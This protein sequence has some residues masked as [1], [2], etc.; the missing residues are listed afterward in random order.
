[1]EENLKHWSSQTIVLLGMWLWD[2]GEYGHALLCMHAPQ[3]GLKIG[4]LLSVTWDD[5][6]HYDDNHPKHDLVISDKETPIRSIN[7][8]IQESI[9]IAYAK[10]PIVNIE[11]TLYMNYKTGKPLTSSTLN[12]ELKRFGED[13]LAELKEKTGFDLQLKTLKTNS[14]EIAWALDMAKKY[15]YKKQVFVS[16]SSFMGHRTVKDT[17]KLLEIEPDDK[18]EFDFDN[19][20]SIH[21][22]M[23]AGIFNDKDALSKFIYQDIIFAGEELIPVLL[24]N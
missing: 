4:T 7:H 22:M 10:L 1:M 2:K 12:R 21:N 13:F 6:M 8:S 20:K 11:D 3:W 23:D 19:I 15:H 24:K 16:L 14:F 9:E 18:I 5:V 17:I